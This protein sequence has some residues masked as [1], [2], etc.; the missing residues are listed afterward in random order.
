MSGIAITKNIRTQLL[1]NTQLTDKIGNK[2]FPIVADDGTTFPFILI[3]K[4]GMTTNYSK[5]GAINDVVNATIEVVDNNYSRA[6]ELSEEIRNTI[7]R[8]KFSN[9]SN[10]EVVNVIEDYVSDSYIITQQYKIMITN[11]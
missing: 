4:S 8:N 1:K 6:V 5:C 9:I 2:I 7:E 10:V 11:Q 3:K